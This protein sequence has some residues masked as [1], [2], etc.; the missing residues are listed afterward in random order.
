M[1]RLSTLMSLMGS[2]INRTH[3]YG[4]QWTGAGA[5]DVPRAIINECTMQTWVTTTPIV[6]TPIPLTQSEPYGFTNRDC[7][8]STCTARPRLSEQ[9]C[10]H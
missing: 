9:L 8:W 2:L 5:N 10:I 6:I 7:L 4:A 1:D 3:C